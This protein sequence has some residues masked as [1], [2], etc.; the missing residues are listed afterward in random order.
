MRQQHEFTEHQLRNELVEWR[1]HVWLELWA[2]RSSRRVRLAGKVAW[3][4]HFGPNERATVPP[5]FGVQVTAG[6]AGDLERWR[7]GCALLQ[8]DE[9]RLRPRV[10]PKPRQAAGSSVLADP[11]GPR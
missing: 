6:L 1:V 10:A 3:R 8:R 11:G 7:D 4:R 2:P 9:L 5:G